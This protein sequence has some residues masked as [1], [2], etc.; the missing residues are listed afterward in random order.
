MVRL[1]KIDAFSQ[2]CEIHRAFIAAIIYLQRALLPTVFPSATGQCVS[3]QTVPRGVNHIVR[4]TARL[5]WES[6][7][8]NMW[9]SQ[10]YRLIH[11]DWYG[12]IPDKDTDWFGLNWIDTA[13]DEL[14]QYTYLVI[15]W[16]SSADQHCLLSQ[17][18]CC[19]TSARMRPVLVLKQ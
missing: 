5:V 8:K 11:C 3:K 19:S 14:T 4:W 10:E 6:V 18:I 9:R 1:E 12:F 13:V 15:S 17:N 16:A 2:N 7:Q